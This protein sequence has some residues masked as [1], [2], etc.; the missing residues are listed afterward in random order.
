MCHFANAP[1]LRLLLSYF[2]WTSRSNSKTSVPDY[3]D[4]YVIDAINARDKNVAFLWALHYPNYCNAVFDIRALRGNKMPI[5][6]ET[7][8]LPE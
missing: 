2:D 5:V 8:A 6:S 4:Q 7:F 3:A 1:M